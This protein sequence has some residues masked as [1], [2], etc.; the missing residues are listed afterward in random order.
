MIADRRYEIKFILDEVKLSEVLSWI[1]SNT[2]FSP[3]FAPRYVNSLYFDDLSFQSAVDNLAGV[4]DRRKM[5]LRWYHYAGLHN[6]SLP[7]LEFKYRTG[8]LGYK[9]SLS[10]PGFRETLFNMK[11]EDF[12]PQLCRE[13][14]GFET[15]QNFFFDDFYFPTLR[16]QYL[17]K[18]FQDTQGLRLTI[19][20]NIKFF[21]THSSSTLL[22]E[23]GAEYPLAVA[24]IKF[25]PHQKQAVVEILRTLN[26][27]PKRHSKYLVGLSTFGQALYV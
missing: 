15:E 4:S 26:L 18:Y 8:R 12:Y 11:M 10:L 5:R 27:T 1:Y 6:F 21:Q 13:L 22:E 14:A 17:R 25:A 24:E 19:D 2:E 23:S 3:I 20:R 16:V 9:K 7:V